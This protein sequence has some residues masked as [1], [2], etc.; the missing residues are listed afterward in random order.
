MNAL[1]QQRLARLKE[2]PQDRAVRAHQVA[3][4]LGT[5]LWRCWQ[6]SEYLAARCT[7]LEEPRH[8]GDCEGLRGC[9]RLG[10]VVKALEADLPAF[11]TGESWTQLH[12]AA[13]SG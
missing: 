13:P 10:D 5:G 4:A 7:M 12:Q 2:Q 9:Y 8:G 3:R 1:A 11:L 6:V